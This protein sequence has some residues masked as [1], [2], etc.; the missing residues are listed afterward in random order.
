MLQSAPDSILV[1]GHRNPDTDT[2]ASAVGYAWLLNQTGQGTY[3]AGR[4]GEVNSQTAFA[5]KRFG[6]DAPTLVSDVRARVIDV[7]EP[8]PAI[9][10]GEKVLDACR[11]IAKTRRPVAVLD[12]QRKPV[13]LISGGG[14]FAYMADAL[15]S[16]SVLALAQELESTA[17]SAI[18]PG[19]MTLGAREYIRDVVNPALRSEQDDFLVVD[20]EGRYVG[21]SRK[22]SLLSP[23]QRKIIMV[24]HNE[25]EQAVPGLAEAEIVEVLDHHR[26]NS[27]PTSIPI[28]FNIEPVGSCSTLVAERGEDMGHAFP[29]SIA[30]L[31]LCG[32]LSDTLIFRS[33]TATERDE[34]TAKGLARMA[35]IAPA[36]ADDK[37]LMAA[38]EGLGGELLGAGAGLAAR[39]ASEIINTDIKFYDV[40]GARVGI[41]QVEVTSFSELA[42]KLP[43]L[44]DGLKALA[45]SEKL[46]LAMLMV[47]DVVLGN[48]RLVS[49]GQTRLISALPYTRIG[50]N[51]LDAPGTVSRKKQLLPMVLAALEQAV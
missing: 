6:V 22:S 3:L 43:E 26:M 51:L 23:P 25:P 4:V 39:A 24:D 29:P 27:L 36:D 15:S 7:T 21:L 16:T 8:L 30:G 18:E 13:G 14:L 10:R 50:E 9:R 40:S 1:L 19:K 49:V 44:Y 48:S 37:Q 5:L 12:E 2:I 45:E 41:A 38:I 46:A 11:S 17:E 20:E 31:L 32:L 34:K 33:P 47:T 35:Q 28:R 42:S